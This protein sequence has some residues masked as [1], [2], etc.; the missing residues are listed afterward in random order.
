MAKLTTAKEAIAALSK[1]TG[2]NQQRIEKFVSAT[3]ETVEATE[4]DTTSD[5]LVGNIVK[6]NS[7][8]YLYVK[9]VS[10]ARHGLISIEGASV[11]YENEHDGFTLSF[12]NSRT[13]YVREEMLARGRV[14]VLSDDEFVSQLKGSL[15]PAET[16]LSYLSGSA[17]TPETLEETDVE[18]V[19]EETKTGTVLTASISS[20]ESVKAENESTPEVVSL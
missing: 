15:V 7:S 2:I 12:S 6:I 17:Q 19:A 8:E 5:S 9:K 3:A 11:R 18:E 10:T 13:Q 20:M 4:F 14:T 1:A 16:L